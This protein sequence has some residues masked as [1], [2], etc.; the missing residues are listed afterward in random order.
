M[1]WRYTLAG[2]T[3]PMLRTDGIKGWRANRYPK[4]RQM[5]LENTRD[6]S[7]MLF[8]LLR[9]SRGLCFIVVSFEKPKIWTSQSTTQ[10]MDSS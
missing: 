5:V 9:P 3:R 1:S 4:R 7:Q 2:S 8:G 6:R 10:L